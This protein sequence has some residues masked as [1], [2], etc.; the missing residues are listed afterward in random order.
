MP[1][2][3]PDGW[4]IITPF[5]AANAVTFIVLSDVAAPHEFGSFVVNRKV[6]VPAKLAAGV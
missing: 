2:T 1:L 3:A 4:V 6:T 5:V